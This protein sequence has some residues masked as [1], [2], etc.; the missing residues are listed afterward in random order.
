MRAAA[1]GALEAF[2][3]RERAEDLLTAPASPPSTR[4]GSPTAPL[5][6]SALFAD[7]LAVV[8]AH[9]LRLPGIR[10]RWSSLTRSSTRWHAF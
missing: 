2:E 3:L 5:R 1:P 4:R 10:A 7:S 8:Q 6:G 9:R